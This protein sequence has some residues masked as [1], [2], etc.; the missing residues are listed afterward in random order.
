MVNILAGEREQGVAGIRWLIDLMLD[1]PEE[2]DHPQL[3]GSRFDN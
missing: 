3:S 2:V 1:M